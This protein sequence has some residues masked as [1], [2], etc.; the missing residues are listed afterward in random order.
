VAYQRL[1]DRQLEFWTP[2]QQETAKLS[3]VVLEARMG[4]SAEN[5]KIEEK[6]MTMLF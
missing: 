3:V 2:R 4:D 1:E 5:V 6:F